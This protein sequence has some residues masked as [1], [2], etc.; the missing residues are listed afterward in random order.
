MDKVLEFCEDYSSSMIN[1][2]QI[3][4]QEE[5]EEIE[6]ERMLVLDHYTDE[7]LIKKTNDDYDNQLFALLKRDVADT[8]PAF[9]NE[10]IEGFNFL[11][12]NNKDIVN[13]LGL[14]SPS[15]KKK[16]QI[17]DY[18]SNYIKTL[19]YYLEN[20]VDESSEEEEIDKQ[21]E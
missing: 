5:L 13:E 3:V 15:G 4:D 20:S 6:N 14:I 8:D 9:F 21:E 12:N 2:F 17:G 10:M 11:L 18:Y 1:L 7:D 19:E 16:M